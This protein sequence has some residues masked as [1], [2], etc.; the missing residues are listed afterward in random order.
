[1]TAGTCV[2][3]IIALDRLMV[4][5]KLGTNRLRDFVIRIGDMYFLAAKSNL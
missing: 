4:L 5:R 1:M 2:V 3:A